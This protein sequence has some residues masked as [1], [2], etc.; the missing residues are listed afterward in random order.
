MQCGTRVHWLTEEGVECEVNVNISKEVVVSVGS[1]EHTRMVLTVF[2]NIISCVMEA[3][4]EFCHF[5][6]A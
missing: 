2:N 5:T 3:K 1:K 4:A 6:K